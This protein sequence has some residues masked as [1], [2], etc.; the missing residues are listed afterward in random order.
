[1]LEIGLRGPFPKMN[2]IMT[3][4]KKAEEFEQVTTRRT[5]KDSLT[6]RLAEPGLSLN[7][8]SRNEEMAPSHSE[9]LRRCS[10]DLILGINEEQMQKIVD[11]AAFDKG[12]EDSASEDP[13]SGVRV[14]GPRAKKLEG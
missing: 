10:Q 7:H 14:G 6:Y 5:W 3:N 9:D 1:M 2:G 12:S 11:L 8:E 13:G 4:I